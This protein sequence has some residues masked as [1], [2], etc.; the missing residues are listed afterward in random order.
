MQKCRRDMRI[1][2]VVW[3]V[4][5]FAT[6]CHAMSFDPFGPFG[7]GGTGLGQSFSVGT[8]G[9]VFL[10]DAFLDVDGDLQF[11]NQ[12]LFDTYNLVFAFSPLLTQDQSNLFLHYSFTNTG[13]ASLTSLWFYTWMDMDLGDDASNDTASVTGSP[14]V[15]PADADPDGFEIADVLDFQIGALRGGLVSGNA[16]DVVLSLGFNLGPLAPG[17]TVGVNVLLSET[18]RSLGSLALT[19]ADTETVHGTVITYSGQV[20]T[21]IPEPATLTT[22]AL[23]LL[24]VACSRRRKASSRQKNS[25]SP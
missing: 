16:A 3:A 15:G 4:V 23:G 25:P 17:S 8:K 21:P 19:Q 13:T 11:L 18:G 10:I 7:E 5:L 14:G 20:G 1:F 22:V 6:P 2:V 9:E 12:D 24:T